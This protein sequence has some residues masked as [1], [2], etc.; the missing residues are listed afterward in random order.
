MTWS[1]ALR[2]VSKIPIHLSERNCL[3]PSMFLSRGLLSAFKPPKLQT[4]MLSTFKSPSPKLET[5]MIQRS[6]TRSYVPSRC[7]HVS[8]TTSVSRSDLDKAYKMLGVSP[9]A[10][11]QE[12]KDAFYRLSA[13]LHRSKHPDSPDAKKKFEQLLAAYSVIGS[14]EEWMEYDKE[15]HSTSVKEPIDISFEGLFGS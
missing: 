5:S 2:V 9:G 8:A 3:P 14:W 4:S 11:Q 13:E 7:F 6:F 15:R 1:S 10:T 12:V